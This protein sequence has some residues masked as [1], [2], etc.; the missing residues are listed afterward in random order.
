M[1]FHLGLGQLI[2]PP[3]TNCWALDWLSHYSS[4]GTVNLPSQES[5][6]GTPNLSS[7]DLSV[8]TFNLPS[9][10]SIVGTLNLP[11]QDSLRN[12]CY[13]FPPSIFLTKIDLSVFK[14]ACFSSK[15]CNSEVRLGLLYQ[16]MILP[17]SLENVPI[18]FEKL[19]IKTP[20]LCKIFEKYEF[21]NSKLTKIVVPKKNNCLVPGCQALL[22]LTL[23]LVICPLGF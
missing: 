22:S 10:D 14:V 3:R 5:S 20:N 6:V 15:N 13:L 8:G 7:Q 16:V 17:H 21:Y 1:L 11:S 4:V 2:C 18:H 23:V 12:L 19:P 9:Q